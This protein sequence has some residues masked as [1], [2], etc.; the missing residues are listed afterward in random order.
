MKVACVADTKEEIKDFTTF[1]SEKYNIEKQEEKLLKGK[2]WNTYTVKKHINSIEEMF[3]QLID[4]TGI[5]P[6]KEKTSKNREIMRVRKAACYLLRN[7]FEL[8]HEKI[9]ELME[10][11][12][13]ASSLLVCQSMEERTIFVGMDLSIE[14][15]IRNVLA[16]LG[17]N[18]NGDNNF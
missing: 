1:L 14:Q 11:K 7:R 4:I 13:H 17:N 8:S 10:Y 3:M 6:R 9:A 18:R 12:S 15:A 2:P 16:S 5:D